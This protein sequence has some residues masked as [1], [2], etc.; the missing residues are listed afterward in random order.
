MVQQSDSKGLTEQG[1]LSKWAYLT[2]ANPRAALMH[3]LYVGM[4]LDE[5]AIKNLI[6]VSRPRSLE[7]KR[8]RDTACRNTFQVIQTFKG[9]NSMTV[10]HIYAAGTQTVCVWQVSLP[11]PCARWC[12][13]VRC[14]S[15]LASLCPV[16]PGHVLLFGTS[17]RS[18]QQAHL[19][20]VMQCFVFGDTSNGKSSLLR[21]LLQQEGQEME[22]APEQQGDPAARVAVNDVTAVQHSKGWQQGKT[23]TFASLFL[24][25]R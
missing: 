11:L 24:A 16:W 17:C 9:W 8:P 19:R 22:P 14:I 10:R 18:Q 15:L 6:R 7:R 5:D 25:M 3:L 13:A 20:V 4:P 12:P 23:A 1:F 2:A 21:G